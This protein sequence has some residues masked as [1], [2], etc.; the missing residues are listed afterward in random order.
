MINRKPSVLLVI[1]VLLFVAHG[2]R[3]Q[4]AYPGSTN[5]AGTAAP[6]NT[7]TNRQMTSDTASSGN[8]T[9]D[10]QKED[11]SD[12]RLTQ[13]IRQSV[14]ADKS[15][16]TYGHNVKIVAVNGTVTLNGVVRSDQ[17]KSAIAM[18][19]EKVAGKSHVVN[20]LKVTPAQ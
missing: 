15:L 12:L 6:D 7:K 2:L 8:P 18:K 13:R 11:S 19:A 16:S 10:N 9:A 3:A 14:V 1:P 5:S 20:E 17:E 4:A